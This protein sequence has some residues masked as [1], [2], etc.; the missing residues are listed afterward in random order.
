MVKYLRSHY[1]HG[2]SIGQESSHHT[3][4][5]FDYCTSLL[6]KC[7]DSY[8]AQVFNLRNTHPYPISKTDAEAL[9]NVSIIELGED[10]RE[11]G[12]LP[13]PG[14]YYG[15]IV[16]SVSFELVDEEHRELCTFSRAMQ[17]IRFVQSYMRQQGYFTLQAKVYREQGHTTVLLANV[18]VARWPGI[19]DQQR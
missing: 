15:R 7:P 19:A 14:D 11:Y 13:I 17:V 9:L 3:I 12:D 10:L 5:K 2:T 6:E 16:R 18:N 1:H 8:I 4:I